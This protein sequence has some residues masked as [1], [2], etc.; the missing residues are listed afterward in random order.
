MKL[1]ITLFALFGTFAAAI[2]PKI[3]SWGPGS[4]TFDDGRPDTAQDLRN[5]GMGEK[6]ITFAF[7]VRSYNVAC[8][9]TCIFYEKDCQ[10]LNEVAFVTGPMTFD[11]DP[12]YKAT[13]YICHP[14]GSFS[15]DG[16]AIPEKDRGSPNPVSCGDATDMNNRNSPLT[17]QG[18]APKFNRI[19]SSSIQPNK[20]T[21]NRVLKAEATSKKLESR[22]AVPELLPRNEQG[23]FICGQIDTGL[24]FVALLALSGT[25]CNIIPNGGVY[26]KVNPRCIC[27]FF[28][29]K[30]TDEFATVNGPNNGNFYDPVALSYKCFKPS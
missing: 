23:D 12:E 28:S 18:T 11:F 2:P 6:C 14:S 13:A 16:T 9:W 17:I 22:N 27:T 10:P 24:Q 1:I 21:L 7:P 19:Q 5:A 26:Y 30:C 4:V 15:A 8:G 29:G 25:R 3:P 20:N